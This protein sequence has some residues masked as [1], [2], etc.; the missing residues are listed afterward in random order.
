MVYW[1]IYQGAWIV[2]I[3]AG[4]ASTPTCFFMK[5]LA[6]LFSIFIVFVIILADK[7]AIPPFIRVL[8]DFQNGDKLGHI[9][10]FGLLSLILN[11]TFLRTL[12]NRDPKRV[13]LSVSLILA[14]AITAE[15]YSQQYFT[16]RTFDMVDLTASSLG[17]VIGALL[18]WN[19]RK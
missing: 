14:L 12:P 2:P 3:K 17:L 10:L 6:V 1:R 9:L 8:Y 11:L 13:A 5:S 18:A 7:N 15:E 16:A 4:W 19:F